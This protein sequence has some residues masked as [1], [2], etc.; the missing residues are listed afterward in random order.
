[1]SC[2]S[3]K[4]WI[5]CA[6]RK[7]AKKSRAKS[8]P[9]PPSTAF[10][11]T[12]AQ[13]AAMHIRHCRPSPALLRASCLDVA[14]LTHSIR[15]FHVSAR[16]CDD[17]SSKSGP[18]GAIYQDSRPDISRVARS[19][20][21][22]TQLSQLQNG[23]R[24][25]TPDTDGQRWTLRPKYGAPNVSSSRPGGYAGARPPPGGRVLGPPRSGSR[26]GP[27]PGGRVLGPPRAGGGRMLGPPRPGGGRRPQKKRPARGPRKKRDGPKNTSDEFGLTDTMLKYLVQLKGER[28]KIR[29]HELKE[30]TQKELLNNAA[31]SASLGQTNGAAQLLEGRLRYLSERK[32][33]LPSSLQELARRLVQGKF[34]KFASERE[35]EAVLAMVQA[36][37]ELIAAKLSAKKG[38]EI[39]PK[40]IE[41]QELPDDP[42]K[43]TIDLLVSGKYDLKDVKLTQDSEVAEWSDVMM[44]QLQKNGS[45]VSSD[46]SQFLSRIN[47]V[48]QSAEAPAPSAAPQKQAKKA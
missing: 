14:A 43:K 13:A 7:R 47:S 19:A 23:Q 38:Q 8:K 26:P 15:T 48:L 22:A 31:L 33:M 25:A 32:E 2:D 3:C 40:T 16:R 39:A 44:Q 9:P 10:Q 18:S 34:V 30:P 27:P 29:V 1:M 36:H 42:K 6:T 11:D 17:D 35:R 21:A 46:Q 37:Q 4:P 45:Y 24:G 12:P 20:A 41:F 28:R 5:V